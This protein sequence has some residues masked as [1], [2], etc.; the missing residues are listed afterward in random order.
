MFYS[1][2]IHDNCPL[3]GHFDAGRFAQAFGE[4][5]CLY[6]L[7]CKGPVTYNAC[8]V[9]KW[10][11]G[12]SFPIQAGHGCI[13]CSEPGFWDKGGFYQPLSQTTFTDRSKL[14]IGVAAGATAGVGATPTAKSQPKK[15]PQ[16]LTEEESS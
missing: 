4:P 13:G 8:A 3:R 7:G 10:N 5:Y 12:V 11:G 9:T 6:K 14:G 16:Q 15:V 1:K 2:L